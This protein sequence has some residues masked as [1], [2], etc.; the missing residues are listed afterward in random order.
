MLNIVMSTFGNIISKSPDTLNIFLF[1]LSSLTLDEIKGFFCSRSTILDI[2]FLYSFSKYKNLF[3]SSF[4]SNTCL[5]SSEKIIFLISDLYFDKFDESIIISQRSYSAP[6]KKSLTLS[7]LANFIPMEF[8][9]NCPSFFSIG[10][11]FFFFFYFIILWRIIIIF[12]NFIF[13]FLSN[14]IFKFSFIY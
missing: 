2:S 3:F 11:I 8:S 9:Y 13:Y 4:F 6:L 7:S 12:F 10:S 14:F 1:L 5:F